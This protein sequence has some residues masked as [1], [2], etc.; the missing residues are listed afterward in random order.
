MFL[1]LETLFNK[2][3]MKKMNYH[4]GTSIIFP[5]FASLM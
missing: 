1:L 4:I 5:K 3:S 2:I